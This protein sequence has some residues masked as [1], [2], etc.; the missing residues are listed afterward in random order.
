MRTIQLIPPKILAI[1]PLLVAQYTLGKKAAFPLGLI[2]GLNAWEIGII[3][4]LSDF[5]L[6]VIINHMFD[7]SF[8]KFKWAMYL[9]ERS[10]RIQARLSKRNWTAG[11]MKIGWLGPLIMTTIPFG[12]GVWTGISLA[13]VMNLSSRQSTFAVGVGVI[14][15]CLIF[16]LAAL[17]ILSIVEISE[18]G[19]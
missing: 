8:E 9:R 19:V 15:G 10:T 5:V 14:L 4:I 16:I 2:M 1:I 7:L 17:G 3:V 11:L 12:G 6:M 18:A 13:R